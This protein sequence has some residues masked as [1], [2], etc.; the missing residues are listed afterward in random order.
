MYWNITKLTY[1]D[2]YRLHLTFENGKEGIADLSNYA[3]RGGVFSKFSD[4]EYF[5]KV[6]LVHGVLTWPNNVDIA[7]ETIYSLATG[8]PL[9]DWVEK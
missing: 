9:P 3:K 4:I 7:P 2:E 5:R 1:L 6:Y 8:E